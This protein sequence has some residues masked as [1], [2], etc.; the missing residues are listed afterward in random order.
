MITKTNTAYTRRV[1]VGEESIRIAAAVGC[2]VG[3]VVVFPTDLK[4]SFVY[5]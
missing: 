5:K 4:L 3:A 2:Y 1:F